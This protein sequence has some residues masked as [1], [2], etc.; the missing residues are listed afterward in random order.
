MIINNQAV[1]VNAS[2][3]QVRKGNESSQTKF[4]ESIKKNYLKE[5]K[6]TKSSIITTNLLEKINSQKIILKLKNPNLFDPKTYNINEAETTQSLKNRN[7][8]IVQVP[9]H[10]DYE[11][12]LNQL[13]QNPNVEYA[14]PDYIKEVKFE[15][16]DPDYQNQWHLNK[17]NMPLA[18]DIT[19][20]SETV[21]IAVIDTGV[22]ST[23]PDLQGRVLPGFDAVT[24]IEGN[25][26]DTDGHGTF[27]AGIIAAN[28]NNVGTV[29]ID[30][31]CAIL[32][33]KVGDSSGLSVS[34]IVEGIYYAIDH[35]VD[36]INMSFGS[37]ESS[38]MEEDALWD[39]YNKG[40]ILVASAGNESR[41]DWAYPA[42]YSPV[43]SVASTAQ[44]NTISTFSNR[45]DWIDLSAPGEGILSTNLQSGYATG[46][47][48][49]FSAPMVSALAGLIKS[50]HPTI[51]PDS[52]Q[53]VLETSAQRTAQE[54]SPLTGYGIIDAYQALSQELTLLQNDNSSSIENAL[55][56]TNQTTI[57]EKLDFPN[58]LDWYSFAVTEPST[59]TINLSNISSFID[60]V[61]VIQRTSTNGT[62]IKTYIDNSNKGGGEEYTFPA[63]L[64]TY[65]LGV[66][67]Y[68][69][70]WSSNPYNVSAMVI[71][72]KLNVKPTILDTDTEI[73]GTAKPGDIIKI[74]NNGTEIGSATVTKYGEFTV[75][76]LAQKGQSQLEVSQVDRYG[77]IKDTAIILV[78]NTRNSEIILNKSSLNLSIYDVPSEITRLE[79]S[80]FIIEALGIE[81]TKE[82]IT[83]TDVQTD[84]PYYQDAATLVD[85][86]IIELSIDGKFLPGQLM[87]RGEY[88]KALTNIFGYTETSNNIEVKDMVETDP[89]YKEIQI[90]LEAGFLTL[91]ED[92]TFRPNDPLLIQENGKLIAYLVNFNTTRQ[93]LTWSSSDPTVATVD[94]TG[95]VTPLS[96]G[97]TIIKVETADGNYAATTTAT[98]TNNI[99]ECF[100]AT[101]AFGSKFAQPVTVFR[102]FR[103]QYLMTN[104]LGRYFVKTYYEV[105]PP[106]ANMI[107]ENSILKLVVKAF[108]APFVIL[109]FLWMEGRE[110]AIILS[111]LF[112]TIITYRK[113]GF[114]HSIN[115]PK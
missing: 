65:N 66:Y 88:A 63:S 64:G 70:H 36:V 49:S 110:I 80:R 13:K 8:R 57:Q 73:S 38:K 20:G 5:G 103:D 115:I 4:N 75:S 74:E 82:N 39:A 109:A 1:F 58:D 9:T 6:F 17:I 113:K 31:K 29:G 91:F 85:Q 76:I 61:G 112:F 18:W 21:T 50:M 62:N 94:Q 97:Q 98:V 11:K 19:K 72:E 30:L 93:K 28:M 68:Y 78:Q 54:W 102:Q 67:D 90:A 25:T 45:G 43:I 81:K 27:V 52:A 87:T 106:I 111:L 46:A 2:I 42:S 105:S 107:A 15:P 16:V 24:D 41:F 33:V 71:P 22:D 60:I 48:T 32:P 56:L 12:I 51:Q 7:Y 53:W 23:H 44:D 83:I 40:I 89:F 84:N 79:F 108:L 37:F 14:E 47:G 95:Q 69:S 55:S 92:G 96:P 100:I 104:E 3:N 59:V 86:G 26:E 10:L 35:D 101:A 34:D 99:D 114:F 77:N